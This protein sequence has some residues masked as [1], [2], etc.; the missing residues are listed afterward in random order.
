MLV[1]YKH[2]EGQG[3]EG[4]LLLNIKIKRCAAL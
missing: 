1:S 2:L 3:D 4:I